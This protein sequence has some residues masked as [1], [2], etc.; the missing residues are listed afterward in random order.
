M[1]ISLPNG[2]RKHFADGTAYTAL[3]QEVAQRVKSWRNS[4][5]DG[6]IQVD[7]SHDKLGTAILRGTGEFW[8]EDDLIAPF[9]L[10]KP[11][12]GTI[13]ARR[14]MKKIHDKDLAVRIL[15][16]ARTIICELVP[17]PINGLGGRNLQRDDIGKWF[18]VELDLEN[19]R[20]N[21]RIKE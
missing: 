14:V 13:V 4:R 8:Q 21:W 15:Q 11:V 3:D 1:G 20:F 17:Y 9:N 12:M 7:I 5:Q 16:D 6:I 10:S 19:K 2:W 18:V